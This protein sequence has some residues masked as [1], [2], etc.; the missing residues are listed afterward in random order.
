[1]KLIKP[2]LCPIIAIAMLTAQAKAASMTW[3][4]SS[5]SYQLPAT[6]DLTATMKTTITAVKSWFTSNPG[7]NA[8]ILFGSGTYQFL[9]PTSAPT[10][11]NKGSINVSAVNPGSSGGVSGQLTFQGAGINSTILQFTETISPS[12][13]S[14]DQTV[15]SEHEIYGDNATHV[16]FDSM[17]LAVVQLTPDGATGSVTQGTVTAEG[18]NT[19]NGSP[20]KY[21][22]ITVPSGFPTPADVYDGYNF[23]VGGGGPGGRYLRSYTYVS[24][25]PEIGTDSQIAWDYYQ[26]ISGSTWELDGL[27]STPS[28]ALGT[29]LAVKSKHGV[30]QNYFKDSTYITFNQVQWTDGTG[31]WFFGDSD[32]ITVTNC[33]SAREAAIMGTVPCLSSNDNGPTMQD[34]S[35]TPAVAVNFANNSFVGNG[36]DAMAFEYVNGATVT[37]N[38]VSDDFARGLFIDTS[39]CGVIN[40]TPPQSPE[41][42]TSGNTWTRCPTVP[43][44]LP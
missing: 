38:S 16:R 42:S 44:G 41:I 13:N 12:S 9:G 6:T 11:N 17:H 34:G 36:D 29:I 2:L 26:Q 1:M 24:G 32:N 30:I 23:S 40:P 5:T 3:D 27:H 25:V 18:T 8:V 43:S 20:N 37:G 7:G 4:L 19:L 39:N 14:T 22:Q 28:Y 21:V 15:F 35:T 10:D 31:L 33:T